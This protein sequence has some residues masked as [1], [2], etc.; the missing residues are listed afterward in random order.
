MKN[1]NLPAKLLKWYDT[2]GRD[3]PWRI[4]DGRA[5][6]PY[7]TWLAEIML[8]QTGVSTVIPYYERFIRSW[9]TVKKLAA[10]K[11][12]EVM[13]AWA[14]LGYYSRA[15][16]LLKCAR[17]VTEH[18]GGKFP[19]ELDELLSLPGV[20][21]YTANAIRAIAFDLPANVV[22]GN[23]ERVMARV[24]A[25]SK[26]S[27]TPQGKKDLTAL[28]A[29]LVPTKRTGDY[30]QGLMDLGATICTPKNPKCPACPWQK[31][32]KAYA[33]NLTDKIPVRVRK[34]A[35]PVRY[36]ISYIVT[37]KQGRILMKQRPEK[38]L[39]GGLWGFADTEWRDTKWS[40]A[41][42]KKHAPLK[43]KPTTLS[44]ITHVFTHFKLI[45]TPVT[46]QGGKELQGTWFA[47]NKLPAMATL[48]K[49]LLAAAFK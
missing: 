16:N 26:P 13:Q 22:D 39:L 41:E 35:T 38:G 49:K 40:E 21:P 34:K 43:T 23:V 6:T 25:Y 12:E 10:A 2:H 18:H 27:N 7:H 19:S 11:D 8:Q 15:R 37:D 14:G 9:P 24:F 20:G 29:T 47:R 46:L 5:E 17:F 42:I 36:G 32:C 31:N 1:A 45:I 30:A 33:L 3:L 4:H 48:H 44:P 28:A